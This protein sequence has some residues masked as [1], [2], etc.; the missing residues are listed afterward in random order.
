M[1]IVKLCMN[2]D[3]CE[4]S[5]LVY[6]YDLLTL[7]KNSKNKLFKKEFIEFSHIC[8]INYNCSEIKFN[9]ILKIFLNL[10]N[11]PEFSDKIQYSIQYCIKSARCS[12]NKFNKFYDYL[13]LA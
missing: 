9:I 12:D 5:N 1:R 11:I 8:V 2:N 6:F 7:Y 10:D 13:L 3:N 4:S